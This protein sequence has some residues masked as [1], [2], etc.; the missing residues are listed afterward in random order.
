MNV[1]STPYAYR[2]NPM[3]V[4]TTSCTYSANMRAIITLIFLPFIFT[5]R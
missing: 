2:T 4:E 3:K 1:L 5:H